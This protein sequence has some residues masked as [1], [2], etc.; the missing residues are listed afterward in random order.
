[1]MDSFY[2]K[3]VYACHL[4]CIYKERLRYERYVKS[5]LDDDGSKQLVW[6]KHQ[7]LGCKGDLML[8]TYIVFFMLKAPC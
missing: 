5:H 7:N 8:I 6:V 1:M 2:G 4:G 3:F